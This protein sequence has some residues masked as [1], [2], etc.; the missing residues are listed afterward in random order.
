MRLWQ[1][2][3]V[4]ILVKSWLT[5]GSGTFHARLVV[6]GAGGGVGHMAVQLARVMG[7]R[8]IAIDTGAEKRKMCLELGAEGECPSLRLHVEE[9]R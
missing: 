8:V 6:P 2:A 1:I 3:N 9:E 7:L 4:V 5:I